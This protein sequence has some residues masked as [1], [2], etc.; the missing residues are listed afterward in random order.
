MS[1]VS[2]LKTEES[3]EEKTSNEL[4]ENQIS[5]SE[6]ISEENNVVES[7]PVENMS[8]NP[9]S[10]TYESES[11]EDSTMDTSV[12]ESFDEEV[13]ESPEVPKVLESPKVAE[14]HK[15]AEAPE[16]AEASTKTTD[17][18]DS[19]PEKKSKES[20]P[21]KKKRSR[22]R[23]RRSRRGNR[24][25]A[26]VTIEVGQK[27]DGVVRTITDFGAFVNINLPQ[28]GLLHISELSRKRVEKVTDVLT[29]KDKV[30]VWVKTLDKEKGRIGLTM[31]KPVA[32]KYSQVKVSDV[33]KGEIT[34]IENY[35]VFID[36]GLERE[37]LIHISELSH[38]Y[39]KS[40]KDVVSEGTVIDVKV[41]KV[42]PRKRQIN[43]SIKALLE[44]PPKPEPRARK[45]KSVEKKPEK[46]VL[47][48]EQ[49][50]SSTTMAVAFQVFNE[51]HKRSK[52]KKKS[53]RVRK[54][55]LSDII[56][57]SLKTL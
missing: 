14:S 32:R 5:V 20:E 23:N 47:I 34:R 31:I 17:S 53:R 28:D 18:S 43:L 10:V 39:V 36:V 22:R 26:N 11:T 19:A 57:Q 4:P 9:S 27:I 35:G 38:D 46:E 56:S 52:K 44:P 21:V 51:T 7:S 49:D 3:I 8:E 33:L 29:I 2:L 13:P 45:P 30:T 37:G 41:L 40:P 25:L 54:D 42:N 12:K 48:P 24:S 6:K 16:A 15:T 1:E 50:L 55:E